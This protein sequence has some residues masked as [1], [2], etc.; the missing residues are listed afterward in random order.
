MR[1]IVYICSSYL[2]EHA[3]LNK[4]KGPAFK[5]LINTMLKKP[6]LLLFE[7]GNIRQKYGEAAANL[8][9][10]RSLESDHDD[11]NLTKTIQTNLL[12]SVDDVVERGANYLSGFTRDREKA[13]KLLLSTMK[14]DPTKELAKRNK[15]A[16]TYGT[17]AAEIE[18]TPAIIP[19]LP[20]KDI[21]E[22]IKDKLTED[23]K[24]ITPADLKVPMKSLV[25]DVAEVLSQPIAMKSNAAGEKYPMDFLIAVEKSMGSKPLYEYKGYK[26][27][28][29]DAADT[30]QKTV[31][32][33]NDIRND[34]LEAEISSE[35]KKTIPPKL[36]PTIASE[37]VEPVEE[38]SKHLASI[39]T[40]RGAALEHLTNLMKEKGDLSLARIQGHD[41]SY[42]DGARSTES[43]CR[44][45]TVNEAAG[46]LANIVKGRGEVIQVIHDG[47]KKKKDKPFLSIDQFQKTY[48]QA[49]EILEEAPNVTSHHID[50]LIM[51]KV[52][53]RVKEVPIGGISPQG[54]AHV[55]ASRGA[56]TS[57]VPRATNGSNL[58]L[59]KPLVKDDDTKEHTQITGKTF[60][61]DLP[62][63]E[64]LQ[65]LHKKLKAR[66]S[67][68]FYKQPRNELTHI[69]ASEWLSNKP[70]DVDQSVKES[71]DTGRLHKKFERKLSSLVGGTAPTM[72][73]SM[74]DVI[75]ETSRVLS[76]YFMT[77]SY[78]TLAREAIIS[79]MQ[80][81]CNDVLIEEDDATETYFYAAQRLKKAKTL[82]T[83]NPCERDQYY[84]SKKLEE[85]IRSRN[86]LRK[87]GVHIKDYIQKSSKYLSELV[88]K[89]DKEIDAYIALLTEMEAAG[90]RPLVEG[91]I[92]KSYKEA[93]AYLRQLTSFDDEINREDKSLQSTIGSKLQNITANVAMTGY[94]KSDLNRVIEQNAK[95]LTSYIKFQGEKTDALKVLV[96]SM[97]KEGENVL[98]R[99]GTL[100]KTY[101]DGANILR[102]KNADQLKVT[103]VDPVVS[104]KIEIKLQNLMLQSFNKYKDVMN[105]VIQVC[106]CMKSVCVQCELW[107]NEIVRRMARQRCKCLRH[108]KE[109][110]VC[111]SRR[112]QFDGSGLHICA[113]GLQ[114]SFTRCPSRHTAGENPS[115]CPASKP[116][117]GCKTDTTA[118]YLLYTSHGPFDNIP[119]KLTSDDSEAT[120]I[121]R[122]ASRAYSRANTSLSTGHTRSDRDGF[123]RTSTSS[124]TLDDMLATNR[125]LPSIEHHVS[126]DTEPLHSIGG[127]ATSTPAQ[128]KSP[129]GT[130][131]T[132]DNVQLKLSK[133]N[134]QSKNAFSLRTPIITTDEMSDWH[135]MMVSLMWNV[136]AW[137]VWIY[138]SI[139]R[140]LAFQERNELDEL[141]A[142]FQRKTTTE[143]LQWYHYDS[144]SRQ[145]I[146]RIAS[147]YK[148][149]RIVSPTRTTVKTKTFLE[150]HDDMLGIIDTFNRWTYW[151]TI[152][153]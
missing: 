152:A 24:S 87:I 99:H 14:K 17:A 7:S 89:P 42:V 115:P 141:W 151:L 10:A 150:S 94:D 153:V 15:Y 104:R 34:I 122:T 44:K 80:K 4:H 54:K 129:L 105:E 145:L 28:Y 143:I 130:T 16:M 69:Q 126:I 121:S 86:T 147:T 1:D 85:M 142:N 90:D 49:A 5:M 93:A 45:D 23:V 40:K 36:S 71:T 131:K 27:T 108:C 58:P 11:P 144:F 67:E 3:D 57:H 68:T 82:E 100:R 128:V 48:E 146:S 84:I 112:L 32:S 92:P 123:L 20:V 41:Q 18:K 73:D 74:Q 47:M 136:Q 114:V 111:P 6:N 134:I 124:D 113:S 103:N 107:C 110:D 106:K 97:E 76:E 91:K 63:E 137:R 96:N 83:S 37:L 70:F 102:P 64:A 140:L 98:L 95:L 19:Y 2:A 25:R 72:Q 125:N 46:N 52:S 116:A 81:R 75:I 79:E 109:A 26:E 88:T 59:V 148:N 149:K 138:D 43:C 119:T 56:A 35:L 135:S 22:E 139:N 61:D 120:P 8:S 12:K 29:A 127:K 55:E 78:G 9:N 60:P 117:S 21:K 66:G 65:M 51:E 133:G 53:E 62:H 39:G 118:A 33:E 77:K 38:A 31:M 132:T 50:P 13:L 30:L 101:Q